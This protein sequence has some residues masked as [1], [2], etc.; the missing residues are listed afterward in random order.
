MD[1]SLNEKLK[2]QLSSETKWSDEQLNALERLKKFIESD[3]DVIVILGNAGTGN[4]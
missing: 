1:F 2:V 3:E 4:F